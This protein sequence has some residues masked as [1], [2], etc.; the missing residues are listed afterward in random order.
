MIGKQPLHS[1]PVRQIQADKAELVVRFEPREACFLETHIVV[2]V[3]IVKAD[4]CVAVGKKT[5]AQ[6][7]SDKPCG[8]GDENTMLNV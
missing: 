4:D 3:Q 1:F 7:K 5:F 2:I 8:S 6:M